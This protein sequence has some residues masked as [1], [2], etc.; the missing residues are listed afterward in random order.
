MLQVR[1]DGLANI[2]WQRQTF[3]PVAFAAHN[4]LSAAPVDVS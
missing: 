2:R 4:D 1:D 3:A